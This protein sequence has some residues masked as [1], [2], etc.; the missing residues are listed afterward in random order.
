[1][2]TET[3]TDTGDAKGGGLASEAWCVTL[4]LVCAV[5]AVCVLPFIGG[6]PYT[7]KLNISVTIASILA[8]LQ[9][10]LK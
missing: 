8:P 4:Q 9:P 2:R 5:C 10:N 6:L 3:D 1:M 7:H